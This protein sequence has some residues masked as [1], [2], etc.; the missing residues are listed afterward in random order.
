MVL[1]T[2]ALC[3]PNPH[4]I[5]ISYERIDWVH[6]TSPLIKLPTTSWPTFVNLR[7]W[8]KLELLWLGKHGE[9]ESQHCFN[10]WRKFVVQSLLLL[11]G[12]DHLTMPYNFS[13]GTIIKE[14]LFCHLITYLL[15]FSNPRVFI[16]WMYQH[17][18]APTIL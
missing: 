2:L 14:P 11:Q 17:M 10:L 7:K 13:F 18:V 5:K 16:G 12:C 1:N 15:I 4:S 6:S 3:A 9:G 8:C